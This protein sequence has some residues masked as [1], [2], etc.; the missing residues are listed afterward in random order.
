MFFSLGVAM[1]RR[2]ST[3]KGGPCHHLGRGNLTM[4]A[5]KDEQRL[6]IEADFLK[7]NPTEV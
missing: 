6:E 2:A 1:N 3:N 5:R 4:K 7:I